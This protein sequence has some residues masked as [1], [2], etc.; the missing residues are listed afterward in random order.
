MIFF[1]DP[2]VRALP[3]THVG[4]KPTYA[5]QSV[6][7]SEVHVLHVSALLVQFSMDHSQHIP[8]GAFQLLILNPLEEIAQ[9]CRGVD[10]CLLCVC[11]CF[12]SAR[13]M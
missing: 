9:M 1:A 5:E 8:P 13:A 3:Q 12:A 2:I 4:L 10:A 11:E 7:A 6:E